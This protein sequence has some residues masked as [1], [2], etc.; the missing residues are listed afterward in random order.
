MAAYCFIKGVSLLLFIFKKGRQINRKATGLEAGSKNFPMGFRAAVSGCAGVRFASVV[1]AE[2]QRDAICC[3]FTFPYLPA[4]PGPFHPGRNA[5][6]A[7][8]EKT[9]K[10][11]TKKGMVI[12][13]D[14]VC[15]EFQFD[16]HSSFFR[17]L[18]KRVFSDDKKSLSCHS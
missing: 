7:A 14:A 11:L 16:W 1:Q 5:C 6:I 12:L 3:V 2:T 4:P 10:P 13:I 17:C 15:S 8:H 9:E 18:N